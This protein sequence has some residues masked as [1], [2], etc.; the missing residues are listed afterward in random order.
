MKRNRL[1]GGIL[2]IAVIMAPHA[3]EAQMTWNAN[4]GAESKDQ[5]V[6]AD[7]F[8]ANELWISEGDSIKWTFVPK[9]EIHTVT[10]LKPAQV[11][12]PFAGPPG[13]FGCQPGTPAGSGTQMSG[14]DYDGSGCVNS[15]PMAGGATYTVTFPTKGNYKLV[16]LVHTDMNG[17]IHVLPTGTPLPHEQNFYDDLARDEARDI[18][19][20]RDERGRSDQD[21]QGT[22]RHAVTA[23]VGEMVATGGGRQYRAVVRFLQG[24]IRVHVG[25]TVEWTNL[26]PTEPHT[27]T[28][29]TE[30]GNPM[31]VVGAAPAAD[32]ALQG[33]I[34]AP[35][36]SVSSGFLAAAPQD[37]IGSPQNAPGTSRI[38]ITFTK[39]GTYK[40]ICALHDVDGMLGTVIVSK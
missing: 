25:D 10:F 36:D 31:M 17:T 29:G 38:R 33:T 15:G 18:L 1:F 32:G 3:S 5:G 11:R 27:V 34:T 37:Q 24:T 4:V 13:S 35:S 19:A 2:A 9:N 16:C 23:G 28:F 7:A 26:D 22:L 6:Q 39:A 20:D 40:Y 12:P 14:A 8:L 30:P 21:D